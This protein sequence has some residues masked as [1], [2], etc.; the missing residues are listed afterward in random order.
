MPCTPIVAG[1][2]TDISSMPILAVHDG[3]RAVSAS[4]RTQSRICSSVSTDGPGESSPSLY[5]A[6][7]GWLRMSR[8]T[9]TASTHSLR[10]V[11]VDR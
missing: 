7:A 6:N 3:C 11:G 1:S 4:A 9:R 2:T 5:G 8:A 10:S